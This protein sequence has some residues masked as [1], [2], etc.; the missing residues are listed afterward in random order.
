M[1]PLCQG[2]QREQKNLFPSR[3]RAI[4]SEIVSTSGIDFLKSL[5]MRGRAGC[6]SI[7]SGKAAGA[8]AHLIKTE[9][10]YGPCGEVEDVAGALTPVGRG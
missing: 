4:R 2:P 8:N 1:H 6:N 5:A 7:A 10:T 9:A 3:E